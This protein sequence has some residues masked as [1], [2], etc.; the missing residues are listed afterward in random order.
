MKAFDP[1]A[2]CVALGQQKKKRAFK[3]KPSN[4]QVIMVHDKS[5][6][7]RGKV[8]RMLEGKGRVQKIEFR[9]E[10]SS[11]E[12]TNCVLQ[13]FKHVNGLIGFALLE[14]DQSG[15]LYPSENKEP[16]GEYVIVDGRRKSGPIY[17]YPILVSLA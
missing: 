16:D 15:R 11:R 4:V 9:R 17:I 14:A 8:R 13:N 3:S 2:E 7:P 1:A 5:N 12:V 10:M 6:I